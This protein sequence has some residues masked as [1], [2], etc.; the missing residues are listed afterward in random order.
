[1]KLLKTALITTTTLLSLSSF[2]ADLS[3]VYLVRSCETIV[4]QNL[5]ESFFVYGSN[6]H[7]Y[8]QAHENETVE[9]KQDS[10]TITFSANDNDVV[11]DLSSD[12]DVKSRKISFEVNEREN[13][14]SA[15][16]GVGCYYSSYGYSLQKKSN[17]DIIYKRNSV[18]KA[19]IAFIVPYYSAKKVRCELVK[20]NK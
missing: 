6:G 3:G 10:K 9:I 4:G 1:M 19:M 15:Q 2:A 17:G 14:C 20:L 12:F 18:D 13:G 8:Y 11:I 16:E 7:P 5:S